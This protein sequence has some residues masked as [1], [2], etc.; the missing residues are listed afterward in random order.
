MP[1]ALWNMAG[2][3]ERERQ[4]A[5][6]APLAVPV[7]PERGFAL[8]VKLTALWTDDGRFGAVTHRWY[9]SRLTRSSPSQ[10]GVRR[11]AAPHAVI[12]L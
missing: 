7:P 8:V 4:D 6:D 5:G 2:E 3:I 9:S 1:I 10:L 11:S 12:R